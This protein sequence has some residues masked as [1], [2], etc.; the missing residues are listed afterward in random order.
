LRDVWRAALLARTRTVFQ[1]EHGNLD[2]CWVADLGHGLALAAIGVPPRRRSPLEVNYGHLL[3]ANGLPIGYG[4][5]TA[6]FRQVNTGIN[7]FPEFRGS[8]APFAWE[9]AL[10]AMHALTGCGRVVINPYQFGAGN[11]EALA[12]GAF[13]FYYRLG[14]R[15]VEPAVR[16]LAQQEAARLADDRRYRVPLRTLRRLAQGDL[17]LDLA[18]DAGDTFFDESWLDGIAAGITASIAAERAPDRPTALRRKCARLAAWLDIDLAACTADVRW[19]L[20]QA[21]PI[22]DQVPDLAAWPAAER[23]ALGAMCVARWA[24]VERAFVAQAAAADRFRIALAA[25]ARARAGAEVA[26]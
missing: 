19:G 5:F 6:L 11:D 23:R 2:E 24:P 22:V 10:R 15:P 3:L 16:A 18:G 14:F 21:A 4:G 12:S 9:Q 20:A 1:A 13:W 8:E 25:V 17:H 26:A 7:V